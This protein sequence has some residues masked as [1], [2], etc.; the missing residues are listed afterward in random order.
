MSYRSVFRPGLFTGQN[1]M[2]TG[3]GSG[4][5]R[6]T[7]HELASLGAHVILLGRTQSKLDTVAAEIAEDGGEATGYTLDIRDEEAVTTR[8]AEIVAAHG[9]IHGLFNNAGGQFPAPITNISKKGFETVV[10]NNLSGGFLVAREVFK[11]SMSEHGGAIVNMSCDMW[12]GMPMMSHTGAARAGMVNLS[13]TMAVEWAAHGV[14]VNAVT[15]GVIASSGM[16]TYED[17]TMVAMIPKLKNTVPLKR[18]GNEAEVSAATVFLL[19]EAAAY[20]T[21]THINIDGGSSCNQKMFPIPMHEK[22]QPFDGFHRE[23]KPTIET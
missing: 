21:G 2:I 4:I 16:D 1:I 17:P 15:P 22:S 19:S 7:A 11:Q 14:R 13:Q 10:I 6:C 5:G 20:I 23:V 3:G 8:V 9:R 18:M 12:G